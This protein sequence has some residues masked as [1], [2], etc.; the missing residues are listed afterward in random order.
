MFNASFLLSYGM[1]LIV[2]LGNPGEKYKNNR[3]N[4]G[5][6]FID[7]LINEFKNSQI[8]KFRL[9][10]TACY[11]NES[12]KFVKKLIRNPQSAIDQLIIVHDDLDIPLGKF[13]IDVGRGPK[14]HNG[15]ESIE[16]YLKTKDF[17][18][19]RIGVDNRQVTG[20][21]DGEAYVLQ[22]FRPGEKNII[23]HTFPKIYLQLEN[24]LKL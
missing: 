5:H 7:Y 24:L 22:N 16:Q 12:G 4:V 23:I 10:K 2:G 18:R 3:H 11:M 6:F 19:V 13:R 15:V 9:Y 8:N 20:P 21:I 17:F 14:L 1:Y